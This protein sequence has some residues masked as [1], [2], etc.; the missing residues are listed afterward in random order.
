VQQS[1]TRLTPRFS[2]LSRCAHLYADQD[3]N[4]LFTSLQGPLCDNDIGRL[5]KGA[6]RV[7]SIDLTRKKR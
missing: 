3:I 5:V 6:L 1:W 4:A 7:D 2:G